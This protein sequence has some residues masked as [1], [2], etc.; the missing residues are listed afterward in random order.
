L[1]FIK[2]ANFPLEGK[3]VSTRSKE[4]IVIWC[5]YFNQEISASKGR[6]ISKKLA[7]KSPT[8][9]ML[10]DAAKDIGLNFVVE[11][12]KAFP[13]RWWEKEGRLIVDISGE[14]NSKTQIIQRLA[15]QM[16]VNEA[17]KPKKKETKKPP[18]STK[19]K[20]RSKKKSKPKTKE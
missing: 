8:I 1:N 11:S 20:K 18:K 14:K 17:K 19:A 2:F 3:N 9:A 13:N 5:S 6:R 12:D 10:K 16:R 7:V 4:K 15:K